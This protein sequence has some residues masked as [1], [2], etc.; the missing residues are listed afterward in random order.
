[1]R[2]NQTNE[3]KGITNQNATYNIGDQLISDGTTTYTYDADGY[4]KEK[5][6]VAG[7]ITYQYD[8][9]GRF[10]KTVTP[11]NTISYR[12]NALGNRVVKLLDG[13]VTEKY[14]W[15]DKTTLLATYDENNNLKQR[16]HYTDSNT[17]DSYTQNGQTYYIVTDHLGSPRAITDDSGA[18][19]RKISYDSF[20]NIITDTAPNIEIPFGF[21][22][23]LYDKDTEFVRF[24]FRDYDPVTGRWT[25]RDP[26]GFSGGDT[27]LYGYVFNDPINFFDQNGLFIV[28]P[29]TVNV[30]LAVI[31]T[32]ATTI[33]IYNAKQKI[34]KLFKGYEQDRDRMS[35]V[36]NYANEL[37]NAQAGMSGKIGEIHKDL[38][39]IS[40]IPYPGS[41]IFGLPGNVETIHEAIQGKCDEK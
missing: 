14:L 35:N 12:H 32:V 3:L 33:A 36:E 41:N 26:I 25:A 16:F 10:K 27:N 28:N 34:D 6:A 21:A 11:T 1:N 17:P 40:Q 13:T 20:G 30:A 19:L 31:S 9:L 39:P 2:T 24:G 7:S 37:Q 22:G 15:L 18:V 29:V 23:G 8:T 5:V 4:L 38:N